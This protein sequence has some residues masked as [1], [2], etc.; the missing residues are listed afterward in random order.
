MIDPDDYDSDIADAMQ[1][2]AEALKVDFGD[3]SDLVK[4]ADNIETVGKYLI[5]IAR[6]LYHAAYLLDPEA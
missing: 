4:T 6:D 2:L 1:D 3:A 5:D